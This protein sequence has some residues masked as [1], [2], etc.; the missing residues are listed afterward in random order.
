[1]RSIPLRIARASRNDNR[2]KTP[3]HGERRNGESRL[4]RFNTDLS[5]A[6]FSVW[7]FLGLASRA[8][9]RNDDRDMAV[10]CFTFDNMGE[11]AEVGAGRLDGPLAAGEEPSLAIGYPALFELLARRGV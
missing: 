11:A 10:A 9:L 5:V 6:P 2:V 1:M 4:H 7:I 3:S 8:C